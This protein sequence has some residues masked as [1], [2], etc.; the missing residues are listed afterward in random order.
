M[1]KCPVL[2][3]L[4]QLYPDRR[5]MTVAEAEA[6][7]AWR[8]LYILHN[9]SQQTVEDYNYLWEESCT[10]IWATSD[11]FEYTAD[12]DRGAVSPV[13]ATS[14]NYRDLFSTAF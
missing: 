2:K 1:T 5:P 13:S 10:R 3:R 7:L 9:G 8:E 11:G 14:G 4:Q 12:Y 6:R